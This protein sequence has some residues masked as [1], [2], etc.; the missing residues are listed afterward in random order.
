MLVTATRKEKDRTFFDKAVKFQCTKEAYVEY[1]LP[2][3]SMYVV[4]EVEKGLYAAPC[5]RNRVK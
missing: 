1:P 3:G 2:I 5:A 4:E